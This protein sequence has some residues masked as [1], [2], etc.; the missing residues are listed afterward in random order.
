VNNNNDQKLAGRFLVE[1]ISRLK[2]GAKYK[3]GGGEQPNDS[4]AAEL[5]IRSGVSLF[6]IFV[7][8]K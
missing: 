2:I 1:D 6:V 5:M 4:A 7:V 3:R 8:Y